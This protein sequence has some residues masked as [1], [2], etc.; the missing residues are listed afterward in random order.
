MRVAFHLRDSI[1]ESES[2]GGAVVDPN[3]TLYMGEG[4]KG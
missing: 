2:V 4:M 3:S 1:F